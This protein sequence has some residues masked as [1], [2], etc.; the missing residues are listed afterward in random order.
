M[1]PGLC[2]SQRL[3][4]CQLIP[5][6]LLTD[7]HRMIAGGGKPVKAGICHGIQDLIRTVE[8]RIRL[9]TQ[10][11]TAADR[12]LIDVGDISRCDRV[13][14]TGIHRIKLIGAIRLG[15]TGVDQAM[16]QIVSD[17]QKTDLLIRFHDL[18]LDRL[19]FWLYAPLTAAQEKCD[20][21]RPCQTSFLFHLIV[22]LSLA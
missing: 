9:Q 14:R 3:D 17:R 1:G 15:T 21:Q 22:F 19:L 20:H 18:F 13:G 8:G 5:D 10:L 16:D 6:A 12:F 2:Q 7:I 11:R 4:V